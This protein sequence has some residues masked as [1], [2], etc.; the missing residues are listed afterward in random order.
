MPNMTSRDARRLLY[1]GYRRMWEQRNG[2][3]G[4]TWEEYVSFMTDPKN[5]ELRRVARI[6]ASHRLTP[7]GDK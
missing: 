6:G 1:Q 7:E 5:V 4:V 3:R 2:Q